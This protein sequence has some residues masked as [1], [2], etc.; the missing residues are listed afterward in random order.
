MKP[1]GVVHVQCEDASTHRSQVPPQSNPCVLV[2]DV[3]D[4]IP[5]NYHY[6]F[7]VETMILCIIKCTRLTSVK[8]SVVHHMDASAREMDGS[9]QLGVVRAEKMNVTEADLR[10]QVISDK[11]LGEGSMEVESVDDYPKSASS[12]RPVVVFNDSGDLQPAVS[13]GLIPTS[14]FQ[15]EEEE[16]TKPMKRDTSLEDVNE[17][18][19]QEEQQHNR[20]RDAV[21]P[22]SEG[23]VE[24]ME[25]PP[26][27]DISR[28]EE[29]TLLLRGS[30]G[31]QALLN[32]EN[33]SRELQNSNAS[34]VRGGVSAIGAKLENAAE[35]VSHFADVAADIAAEGARRVFN[36]LHVTEDTDDD[37]TAVNA[38]ILFNKG[39]FKKF[40]Q[41]MFQHATTTFLLWSFFALT[42]VAVLA[43]YIAGT[44]DTHSDVSWTAHD[45]IPQSVYFKW[46]VAL[47]FVSI[48]QFGFTFALDPWSAAFLI[49]TTLYQLGIFF[50]SLQHEQYSQYYVPFFLRAWTLRS[51]IYYM[52]D[53]AK[54]LV[55]RNPHLD[56]A[57]IVSETILE[58]VALLVTFAGIYRI[59]EAMQG[60]PTT[61]VEAFYLM[62]VTCTTVGYGDVTPRTTTG[63]LL[64]VVFVF[65]FVA[66]L[67]VVLSQFNAI[68]AYLDRVRGF[69]GNSRHVVIVG[70]PTY[71]EILTI[72]NEF[73]VFSGSRSVVFVLKNEITQ[74]MRE[75][76]SM[77]LYRNR[78]SLLHVEY[79][80]DPLLLRRSRV[81]EADAVILLT[82]KN[83]ICAHGD[84]SVM[85]ASRVFDRYAEHVPQLLSLRYGTHTSLLGSRHTVMVTDIAKK[86]ILSTALLMPGVVPFLVNLVRVSGCKST[87]SPETW[88]AEHSNNWKELYFASR[89]N[90]LHCVD[91]PSCCVGLCLRDVV[92]HFA[93][94]RV[95]VVGLTTGGRSATVTLNLDDIVE[96]TTEL[97][98]LGPHNDSGSVSS[99]IAAVAAA[100]KAQK[101]Y[102]QT[103]V[104]PDEVP[105]SPANTFGGSFYPFERTTGGLSLPGNSSMTMMGTMMQGASFVDPN[106]L[107]ALLDRY[108]FV[109]RSPHGLDLATLV[110]DIADISVIEALFAQYDGAATPELK[111]KVAQN[112]NTFISGIADA[113]LSRVLDLERRRRQIERDRVEQF[114]L[115]DQATSVSSVM[116]SE[117]DEDFSAAMAEQ[118]LVMMM[119]CIRSIYARS[120]MTLLSLNV[121]NEKFQRQWLHHF[122]N[123]LRLVKG[124]G[125]LL[126]HVEHALRLNRNHANVR[127]VLIYCSQQGLREYEDVPILT[128]EKN[129]QAMLQDGVLRGVL[130]DHQERHVIVELRTFTSCPFFHPQHRDAQWRRMGEES[131]QSSLSFMMGKCF[132]A[133]MLQTLLVH[134]FY[135]PALLK[136]Y[137]LLLNV[138][139]RDAHVDLE[140][141]DHHTNRT[142]FKF[143]GNKTMKLCTFAD[144]FRAILRHRNSIAV[145]V[146]RR[147]PPEEHLEG[148]PR[149]FITNPDP[150]MPLLEDDVVYA[151]YSGRVAGIS[152][153]EEAPISSDTSRDASIHLTPGEAVETGCR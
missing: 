112:V 12:I 84:Y 76:E 120:T 34:P 119:Q 85:M 57:R 137:E 66:M 139:V 60:N 124:Q 4:F 141:N 101:R 74:R 25:I 20:M 75:L 46:R 115:I 49:C 48:A 63:K 108:P 116:L 95:L 15:E 107:S 26:P 132:S 90:K 99:A 131:F 110:L 145:G 67:P 51:Y 88:T 152:R 92:L 52:F 27:I 41:F 83:T 47:S 65:V 79:L 3:C 58:F 72:L 77:P 105:G 98:M 118:N 148:T 150:S 70:S 97:V 33:T 36:F 8:I 87:I 143:Y 136:W 28:R 78:I 7:A 149:Y 103:G 127:G 11:P 10:M 40:Q 2:C 93:P 114:V 100:L 13:V 123:P 102:E 135:H 117:F 94:H 129:V 140:L 125:T 71:K 126:A 43:T 30:L 111:E 106:M 32:A 138:S 53:S 24:G 59:N 104:D 73:I 35:A 91:A 50:A 56:V 142:R 21:S 9:P 151:L 122:G 128:V 42:E 55:G 39:I 81:A 134:S 69:S 147:F 61:F 62:I 146:F 80:R 5:Y 38:R 23:L 144:A 113:Q 18:D 96:A 22:A 86:A 45:D 153:A 29:S 68:S 19:A 17:G 89:Q 54:L 133:D 109:D 44:T 37:Y 64:V 121:L 31:R 130:D 14:V 16:Q 6:L 1:L 82:N